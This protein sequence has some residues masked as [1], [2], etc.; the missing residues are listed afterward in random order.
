MRSDNAESRRRGSDAFQI[1]SGWPRSILLTKLALGHTSYV[2]VKDDT[3]LRAALHTASW[4]EDPAS[5]ARQ[6]SPSIPPFPMLQTTGGENALFAPQYID[7]KLQVIIHCTPHALS[8][9]ACDIVYMAAVCR[10]RRTPSSLRQ[11]FKGTCH[12]VLLHVNQGLGVPPWGSHPTVTLNRVS[13]RAW[14]SVYVDSSCPATL[15]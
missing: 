12:A 6:D 8:L 1:D 10:C 14:F 13:R 3:E 7:L 9:Y 4:G 2:P 5:A 11:S 15:P